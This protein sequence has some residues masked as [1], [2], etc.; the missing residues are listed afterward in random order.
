MV[1]YEGVIMELPNPDYLVVEYTVDLIAGRKA[2]RKV[3]V[4]VL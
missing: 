1:T 3:L 4:K 2:R